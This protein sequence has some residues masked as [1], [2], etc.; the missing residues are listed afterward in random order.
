MGG[1]EKFLIVYCLIS[2]TIG[3]SSIGLILLGIRHSDGK[4]TKMDYMVGGFLLFFSPIILLL[5]ILV[6]LFITIKRFNRL[7][8]TH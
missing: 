5:V 6:W 1:L 2:Y 3:I 4:V 8:R 7:N